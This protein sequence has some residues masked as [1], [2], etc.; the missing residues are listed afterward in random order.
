MNHQPQTH[1]IIIHPLDR[2]GRYRSTDRAT[3]QV[4]VESTRVP[5]SDT[6]RV[7]VACGAHPAD[8]IEMFR[9][10]RETPDLFGSVGAVARFTVSETETR[11][12]RLVRYR[13][14]DPEAFE[15][16][17]RHAAE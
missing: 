3:G 13:P 16:L 17:K 10:G 7:L 1:Q 6:A 15:K 9:E 11:G 2:H 8:R 14:P 5:F 12:P 4:W